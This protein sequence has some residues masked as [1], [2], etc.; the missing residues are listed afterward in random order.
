MFLQEV[1]VVEDDQVPDHSEQ[2]PRHEERH[3][4]DEQHIST[5]IRTISKTFVKIYK[6]LNYVDIHDHRAYPIL[7]SS[8]SNNKT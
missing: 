5:I 6:Y 3:W 2:Q 7:A 1:A 8:T 4:E